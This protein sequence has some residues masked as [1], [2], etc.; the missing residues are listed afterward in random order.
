MTTTM[1][2]P[3]YL[4]SAIIFEADDALA[5]LE[6]ALEAMAQGAED[7][8]CRLAVS[9]GARDVRIV[10]TLTEIPEVKSLATVLD[11]MVGSWRDRETAIDPEIAGDLLSDVRGVRAELTR[12]MA[13]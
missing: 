7:S 9:I 4:T 1:K 3:N 13:G 12:L 11:R 8:A 10:A 5:N 6:S 2:K